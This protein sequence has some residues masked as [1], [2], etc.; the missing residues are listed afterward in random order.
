MT[1]SSTTQE[2][3]VETKS[4][5]RSAEDVKLAENLKKIKH[6]IMVMSGKGGVGKSTIAV[7][8]A[9]GLAMRGMEVG[10]LDADIHGPNVPKM[11][12]VEHAL[13]THDGSY[14]LPVIVAPNVRV[15]SMAF[16]LS[17]SDAAVIWRGPMKMGAIRQFLSEVNWG[18]LDYLIID[19]PPGTGDEPLSIAQMIPDADG[20]IIVTTP[21]DVALLDASKSISFAKALNLPV[22][23]VVENMSG[24]TCPHCGKEIALFKKGGG[25]RLATEMGV[26]FLGRVPFEVSAVESGD[27]GIPIVLSQPDS[28]ASKAINSIIDEVIRKTRDEKSC[29]KS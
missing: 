28:Q 22:I 1:M 5:K 29:S 18:V 14:I 24:F 10:I 13:L 25:E 27:G 23:G 20:V 17:K 2:I 3:K 21:Q 9:F 6:K 4:S 19:L 7:N 26:A 11:L 8:L 12:G 15:I 16:L